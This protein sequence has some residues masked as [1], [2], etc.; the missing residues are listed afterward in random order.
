MSRILPSN[1]AQKDAQIVV[2]TIQIMTSMVSLFP[3]CLTGD[4]IRHISSCVHNGSP[5]I[6][7]EAA[8]FLLTTCSDF[9]DANSMLAIQKVPK[10]QEDGSEADF[11]VNFF[12]EPNKSKKQIQKL[13]DLVRKHIVSREDYMKIIK[14]LN[15]EVQIIEENPMEPISMLR[16][17]RKPLVLLSEEKARILVRVFGRKTSVLYDVKSLSEM[18]SAENQSD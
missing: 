6:R 1:A 2:K 5:A 8:N 7:D 3:K 14:Q 18:L 4:S 11:S 15:P 13:F 17:E 16:Q 10:P 9:D 12:S